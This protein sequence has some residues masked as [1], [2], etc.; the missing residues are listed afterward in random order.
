MIQFRALDE[1]D[2][3][4]FAA[5]SRTLSKQCERCVVI[6]VHERP[7][8]DYLTL[9]LS[10]AFPEDKLI[11]VELGRNASGSTAVRATHHIWQ[12]D[13]AISAA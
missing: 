11:T 5:L 12:H 9:K 10:P 8:F 13:R 2:I 1:V 3:S 7:L 4:Q 6:A